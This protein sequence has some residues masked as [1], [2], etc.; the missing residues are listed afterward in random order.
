MIEFLPVIIDISGLSENKEYTINLTK[1][2][3]IRAISHNT[4]KVNLLL[5]ELVSK[6]ISGVSVNITNLNPQYKVTGLDSS[7]SSVTVIVKGSQ[8]V[9]DMIDSTMIKASVDLNKLG[10]G[11]HD[12]DVLV[13][14]TDTRATYAARTKKIKVRIT[15]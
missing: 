7:S 14:G 10:I 13:S 15:D 2:V 4:I 11:D 1:P 12:V 9:L 6:E 3:G 8:E 5:G